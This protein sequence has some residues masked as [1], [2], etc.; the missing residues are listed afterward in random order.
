MEETRSSSH[1][2]SSSVQ[3]LIETCT[4]TMYSATKHEVFCKNRRS[5]SQFWH[6]KVVDASATS[7]SEI[8]H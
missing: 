7:A 1:G 3:S 8:Y 4:I 2:L 6:P 5:K